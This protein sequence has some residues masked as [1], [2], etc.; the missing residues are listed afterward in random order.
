MCHILNSALIR[1]AVCKNVC[2]SG[3]CPCLDVVGSLVVPRTGFGWPLEEQHKHVL[4]P[5]LR[6]YECVLQEEVL[7]Q[8]LEL[9]PAVLMLSEP[10]P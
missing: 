9:S 2:L 4:A 6:E 3:M 5:L 10:C 8:R 1:L 7:M